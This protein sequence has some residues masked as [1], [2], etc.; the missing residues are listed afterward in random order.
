MDIGMAYGG[1]LKFTIFWCC[2]SYRHGQVL[3]DWT[4][5][6]KK[7]HVLRLKNGLLRKEKTELQETCEEAKRLLKEVHEKICGPCAE[8]QQVGC[9]S[10]GRLPT[11]PN[12]N[13][14]TPM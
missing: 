1:W 13:V 8:Q 4:Q 5:L 12:I 7:V 10:G 6:K 9:G 11:C 14:Q 3:R 2:S